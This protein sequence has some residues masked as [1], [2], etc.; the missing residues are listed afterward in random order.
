MLAIKYKIIEMSY[1]NSRSENLFFN[2]VSARLLSFIVVGVADC[3]AECI[4]QR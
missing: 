3:Q 1:P 4:F 2:D